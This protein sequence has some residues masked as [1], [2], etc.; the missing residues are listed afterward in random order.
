M[1]CDK[2]GKNSS[3]GQSLEWIVAEKLDEGWRPAVGGYE[4]DVGRFR[5]ITTFLC[6]E[7]YSRKVLL[8]RRLLLGLLAISIIAAAIGFVLQLAP[9]QVLGSVA[10]LV[11]VALLIADY[12]RADSERYRASQLREFADIKLQALMRGSTVM[13]FLMT[14]EEFA[15]LKKRD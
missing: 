2:C 11:F 8:G 12:V 4:A 10:S 13:H 3:N 15:Q 6:S 14:P 5:K 9:L 7:C 1:I